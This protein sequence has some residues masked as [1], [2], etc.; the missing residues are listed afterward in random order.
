MLPPPRRGAETG[1][2]YQTSCLYDSI[3][4]YFSNIIKEHPWGYSIDYYLSS[5]YSCTP[6]YI[7]IFLKDERVTT[8]ILIDLL[9]NLPAEKNSG[10]K[11]S[12]PTNKTAEKNFV[13]VICY[14]NGEQVGT[15]VENKIDRDFKI[16][17]AIFIPESDWKNF[18]RE[19][20]EIFLP[21]WTLEIKA[22]NY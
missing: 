1:K 18:S 8:D 10:K 4:E 2:Q 6:S 5:L 19:G 20:N 3:S 16:G 15:N 13:R 22:K 14:V 11:N 7:K 12:A 21:S 9:K 17:Q